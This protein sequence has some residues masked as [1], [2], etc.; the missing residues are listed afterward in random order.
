M[1]AWQQGLTQAWRASLLAWVLYALGC[2]TLF[3][4]TMGY[5]LTAA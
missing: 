4:Q 3:W 5:S 2:M 1:R